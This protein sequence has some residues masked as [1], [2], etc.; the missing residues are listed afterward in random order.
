MRAFQALGLAVALSACVFSSEKALF[1]ADQAVLP[2]MDGTV[3]RWTEV[4][5][6]ST[7]FE[8]AFRRSGPRGYDLI[9]LKEPDDALRGILL[10]PIESTPEEDY[11]AQTPHDG[12]YTYALMWR[13]GHD[14]RIVVDPG[15]I[16]EADPLPGIE[17]FCEQRAY[18]ECALADGDAL[19]R[20]Y[21]TLIY[22]RYVHD[23]EEPDSYITLTPEP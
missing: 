7:A 6:E 8:V 5:D 21:Q 1:S 13:D 20:L 9:P 14:Y 19:L 12:A 10:I 22:P 4:Q 2:F 17:A 15:R 3:F 11:I 23:G 16:Q 18:E